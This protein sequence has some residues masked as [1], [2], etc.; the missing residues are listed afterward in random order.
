MGG[1]VTSPVSCWEDCGVMRPGMMGAEGRG[2]WSQLC[3]QGVTRMGELVRW[4]VAGLQ[5]N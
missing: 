5:L 1:T 4:L 2:S 3:D